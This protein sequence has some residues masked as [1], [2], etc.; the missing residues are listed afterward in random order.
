MG[1]GMAADPARA[2]DDR[3]IGHLKFKYDK[4]FNIVWK[5]VNLILR[6]QVRVQLKEKL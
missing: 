5:I 1:L 3:I 4:T 6:N 2:E